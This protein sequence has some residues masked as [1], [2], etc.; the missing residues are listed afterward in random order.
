MPPPFFCRKQNTHTHTHT[1]TETKTKNSVVTESKIRNTSPHGER[2]ITRTKQ[3][4]T[5]LENCIT[6]PIY[7]T[8]ICIYVQSK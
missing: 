2:L 7:I 4:L 3:F 6:Q 8:E 5:R 1:H